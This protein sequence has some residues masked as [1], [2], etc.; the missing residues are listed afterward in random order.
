MEVEGRLI[1]AGAPKPVLNVLAFAH[2]KKASCTHM[3]RRNGKIV[4]RRPF[5]EEDINEG[6]EEYNENHCSVPQ[7]LGEFKSSS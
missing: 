7:L 6:C 4:Q 3:D 2:D 1:N 5:A